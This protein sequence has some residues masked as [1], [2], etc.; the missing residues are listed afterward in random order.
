MHRPAP[1][2]ALLPELRLVLTSAAPALGLDSFQKAAQGCF[3]EVFAIPACQTALV[4][5][6]WGEAVMWIHG[7]KAMISG[8]FSSRAFSELFFG[9]DELHSC[10][11]QK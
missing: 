6:G 10:C 2:A 8:S 7:H 1:R 4:Q 11:C 5:T 9:D 3:P